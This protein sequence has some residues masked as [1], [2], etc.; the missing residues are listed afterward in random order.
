[1]HPQV[2][3]QQRDQGY[4]SPTDNIPGDGGQIRS[5]Q[6]DFRSVFTCLVR[7][8][9]P[10]QPPCGE[11]QQADECQGNGESLPPP[12]RSVAGSSGRRRP[13]LQNPTFIR[14]G[15]QPAGLQILVGASPL[16]S[17]QPPHRSQLTVLQASLELTIPEKLGFEIVACAFTQPS[18]FTLS[19]T[20]PKY[21]LSPV[22]CLRGN[23]VRTEVGWIRRVRL[24]RGH[25]GRCLRGPDELRRRSRHFPPRSSRMRRR[26][27]EHQVR[28]R[29]RVACTPS[30]RLRLP[31]P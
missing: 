12:P 4:G 24:R 7:P 1:M 6:D 22:E 8:E 21:W 16:L 18:P 25:V 29:R 11:R 9:E 23:A 2:F 3:A 19:R 17:V 26:G 15:L 20:F 5:P 28:A 30:R 10:S 14:H 13:R 27:A 31:A